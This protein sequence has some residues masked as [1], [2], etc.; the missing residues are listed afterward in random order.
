MQQMKFQNNFMWRYDP[1]GFITRLRQKVK[2][3]PYIHHPILEIERYASQSEWFENTLVD[4]DSTKVDVENTLI[5][6][7]R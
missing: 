2:L 1:Q 4:R 3:G 6:L 5:D 7:E